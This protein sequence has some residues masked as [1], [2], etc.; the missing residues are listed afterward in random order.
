MGIGP[1]IPPEVAARLGISVKGDKDTTDA[2]TAIGPTLPPSQTQSTA[3]KEDS[4]N[5]A[6]GPTMPATSSAKEDDDA[7]PSDSEDDA[8][9]P[10]LDMAGCTE[11]QARQQTLDLVEARTTKNE[12]TDPNSSE[13]KRGSWM[14]VPPSRQSNNPDAKEPSVPMFDESW[15]ETP[16]E[17]RAKKE[18]KAKQK[19]E[20]EEETPD[21]KRKRKEEEDQAKWIEEFNKANRPKSLLEMHLE[22]KQGKKSKKHKPG[23]KAGKDEGDEEDQWKRR[24]FD[25]DRDLSTSGGASSSRDVTR[26]QRELLS[27]MGSYL[28]DKYTSGKGDKRR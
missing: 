15:T 16:A 6:I 10:S 4:E 14:L 18:K 27:S 3:S 28:N 7:T 11:D 9:G 17:R 1:Q 19:L 24:R 2:P 20:P 8:I 26:R 5:R 13:D 22:A 12:S 25:R 23:D 21:M